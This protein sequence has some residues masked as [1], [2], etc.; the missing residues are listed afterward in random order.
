MKTSLPKQI[1]LYKIA[2]EIIRIP[3]TVS[4]NLIETEATNRSMPM[5]LWKW[6]N[7]R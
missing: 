7:F 4:H 1:H 3:D 5:S 2:Q 6:N